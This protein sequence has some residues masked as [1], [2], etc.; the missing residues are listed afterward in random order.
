LKLKFNSKS[1][2]LI[3][4]GFL[5]GLGIFVGS[6]WLGAIGV[7]L[8]FTSL[9]FAIYMFRTRKAGFVY[10]FA[11]GFGYFLPLLSWLD[12]VG[13][14][15]LI[16]L[17]ALCASWWGL[18]FAALKLLDAKAAW[19]I[20]S[21]LTSVEL[22]RDRFPWSGFGWGQLSILLVDLPWISRLIP[23]F[24][25]VALTWLIY[26]A[27]ATLA[28]IV[29]RRDFAGFN[30]VIAITLI[31]PVIGFLPMPTAT[32]TETPDNFRIGIVQGGVLN[33]GLG[34][35]G[36]VG[37]V[38]R[39]HLEVTK[40]DKNKLVNADLVV[41]PE[42][43][44]DLDLKRH[45]EI[46][47]ELMD[48]AAEFNTKFLVNSVVEVSAD[49]VSNSSFLITQS[50]V[51]EIYQKQRLVP[52][53]EFLP[54]R[55]LVSSLTS[56]ADLMPRDFQPGVSKQP[57]LLNDLQLVICFEIADDQIAALQNP[58]RALIVQT[59]NATYQNSTQSPQQ[60]KITRF[61]AAELGIPVLSVAT[62]GISGIAG[63]RGEVVNLIAPGERESLVF[64][65]PNQVVSAPA[66]LVSLWIPW[67]VFALTAFATISRFR[68]RK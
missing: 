50:N 30:K 53:G 24:G 58:G 52:F 41:W 62:S 63:S 9:V 51:T 18:G 15:A 66:R 13:I 27:A 2:K 14:D 46:Q 1:A 43:A 61:R 42:S 36:P 11:V 60:F 8:S 25:Q 4:L 68:L 65:V 35:S 45:P 28:S 38:Y 31:A 7:G 40:R 32:A 5:L 16:A 39:K 23:W 34:T 64:D 3:P 48:L 57:L 47:Q 10:G 6:S 20:A 29:I 49:K 59:N 17:A 19:A 55:D 37:V 44:I 12:V 22:I 67:L 33:Y 56:R 21:V 26:F 54:L